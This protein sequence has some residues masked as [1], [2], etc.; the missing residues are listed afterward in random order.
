MG[1]N[2]CKPRGGLP[3]PPRE[4]STGR[5]GHDP[6]PFRDPRAFSRRRHPGTGTARAVAGGDGRWLRS[7]P[8]PVPS[9]CGRRLNACRRR[10][11]ACG[12]PQTARRPSQAAARAVHR[13][14]VIRLPALGRSGNL[15][16]SGAAAGAGESP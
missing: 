8:R 6:P 12:R 14:G 11:N 15:T 3:R 2:A 1:L 10:L 5:G 4:P 9:A 7:K 13:A 16:P